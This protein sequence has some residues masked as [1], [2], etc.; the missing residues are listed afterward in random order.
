MRPFVR[1]LVLVALMALAAA[2]AAA[3]T[4]NAVLSG[5]VS[6]AQG[7]VLPGVT[8]TV[9]N[10][11]TGFTRTVV[12]EG[13]GR[14]RLAGLAPGRYD[15]RVELQGFGPVA[16]SDI[17]LTTGGEVVR[18][19][20]MQVQGVQESV[21]VSAEAPV[22]ETTRSD[23]SGVVT[24]EQMQMLPL[25]SRQP[26]GLALLLPGTSQDAV[27][28]RK[29]NANIGAG[30]FTMGSA[31][32]VDG[33]WN[34]EGNTGEPRQDF[35][36]AAIREFRVLVS[37]A[38]A[39]Y[40]WTA[41]GAVS[42]ATKSGTNLWT[43][44]VFEF[45]RNKSLNTL[46]MFEEAAGISKPD[47]DR[48]QFGGALGGP[49]IRDRL[50]FFVAAERTDTTPYATVT[51]GRPDLYRAV[52]GTFAIPEY[53]NMVF[54]R[55]DVQIN[56]GQTAFA[57]YA[58]QDSDF[59]CEGCGGTQ[60]FFS[61]NGIQQKRY[62]LVAGHTWVIS[63]RVF[64]EMRGQVT[65]YHFRQ[66][67]PG[68]RPLE[69]LFD[70]SPAR[71]AP[72][73]QVYVF[74]SLTWGTNGNYYTTQYARE[75]RNDLSIVAGAHTWKFGGAFLHLTIMGDL[76]D[77]IG[78]W[79]FTNDQVFD[80]D[81][82]TIM[83]NLTGARLF[84]AALGQFPRY[85][86]NQMW[87]GYIQDEWRVRPNLTLN[88]GLRYD[89]Q[90]KAFN[91]ELDLDDRSVFPTTGTDRQI[92]YV[93]F[94]RR[95][96]TNNVGPRLGLAWD[97]N[98]GRS[99][100]RAGY[101]IYYNP[102]NLLVTTV[103]RTNFRQASITIANPAYPDPYRGQDPL[104]FVSTAPQ[105]I[106]ILANDLENVESH[107][108]TAGFSQE[109]TAHLA[110]HADIVYN[111]MSKVPQAIDINPRANG[112]SGPRPLNQFARIEETR[113]NG[114]IDYKALMLKL[115][116]RFDN[117]F[118][119]TVSYTLAKSDGNVPS[120]GIN[121]RVTQSEAPQLDEGPAV[122]DRRHALVASGSVLLPSE[123]SLGAVWQLRSVMPFSA[124]AGVDLNGDGVNTD[125][126]PGTTRNLGNRDN[127]RMLQAVNQWR[128]SRGLGAIPE[129][130]IDANDYKAIDLRVSK[131]FTLGG[132][133]R[134][135]LI[136]QVF[137]LF[138][139][140]NLA[141]AWVTNALSNQFGRIRQAFN[142]QQGEVAVRFVW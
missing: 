119:Y 121:S 71:T 82:P 73:T 102:M 48:H 26:I 87:N 117:R 52:E 43:G 97:L 90:H 113:S 15:L 1:P 86:P 11:E 124:T 30:A 58:W 79:T 2:P 130:Q 78:T 140:D 111:R 134:L 12:T 85:V 142:R 9:R 109:L 21:Q 89:L 126:V 135:E 106:S 59:T 32:L 51:T 47:F 3:Q 35:P 67:P 44:E 60:A 29:F 137:N 64:N 31:L 23:V 132:M 39:E 25:E 96:D 112:T 6:D 107:A 72:L 16:V 81:N 53:S 34:K 104:A 46:N 120:G 7:G 129:S 118:L 22:V 38:P 92:P 128:A 17:T 131:A 101:G 65:N 75:L 36:Q 13:D 45:L 40:G 91:E 14:Y 55:G 84:T 110:I 116:R 19:V 93:D 77:N 141:A 66:H 33:V 20:T 108:T 63:S 10:T 122:N 105:N 18:D 94:S 4:T 27:R 54:T 136:G 76:R 49:I 100:V 70:N 99:V 5:V 56:Q 83:R 125:Y 138:G 88:L 103:E 37:Q 62:S 123:V 127:G 139:R 133:R 50:H 69:N 114:E 98:E 80:P 61:G 8:V 57:R 24:Q 41:G 95:G 42:F 115:D 28:P 74:P 68:V